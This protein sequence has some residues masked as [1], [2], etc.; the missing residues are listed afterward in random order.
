MSYVDVMERVTVVVE[1][2]GVTVIIAG[3]AL[4]IARAVRDMLIGRGGNEAY[5]RVRRYLGR[6]ILFGLEILV[7]ADL[8]R[9]VAVEPTLENVLVLG[10]IVLIRTF[11]SFSLEVEI[12]GVVPWRRAGRKTA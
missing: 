5:E 11:L 6:S 12:E 3:I 1:A 9:T 8:I 10:A 2:L 4:A 7:A